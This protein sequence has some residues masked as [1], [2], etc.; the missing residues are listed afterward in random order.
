MTKVKWKIMNEQCCWQ[1]KGSEWR[2]KSKSNATV[3]G[4]I[5]QSLL[6]KSWRRDPKRWPLETRLFHCHSTQ[7]YLY[8]TC[9]QVRQDHLPTTSSPSALTS[10][11][12]E[13][14]ASMTT[15]Q[16]SRVSSIPEQKKKALQQY[17]DDTGHFSLV[18]WD[19][20]GSFGSGDILTMQKLPAG[21]FDYYH[22]RCLWYFIHSF[23][24]S[25][26]FIGS[27][28]SR[29]SFWD[30]PSNSLLCSSLT[31]TRIRFRR[32]GW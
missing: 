1:W 22:E 23:F 2:E 4:K 16:A 11:G 24:R 20:P 26:P 6:L 8:I 19:T 7:S 32:F 12:F 9:S 21:R 13:T 31:Y 27:Q 25:I 17:K 15:P 10:T 30:R 28:S 5:K 29:T 18:R 3:Q 14:I